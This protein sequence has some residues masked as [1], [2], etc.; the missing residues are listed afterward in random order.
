MGL[1]GKTQRNG[2]EGPVSSHLWPAA[3]KHMLII[4]LDTLG[5][6]FNAWFSSN[7]NPWTS[8][9][10]ESKYAHAGR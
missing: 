1:E 3:A 8:H 4:M 9:H 10:E 6:C 5:N 2:Q 7:I